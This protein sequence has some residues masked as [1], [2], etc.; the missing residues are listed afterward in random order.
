MAKF[1]DMAIPSHP[2]IVIS[3]PGRSS[4]KTTVTIGLA[5]ALTRKAYTVQPFKKGPDYIDPMWLTAASGR[6]CYNLDFYLMGE[7]N[8]IDSFQRRSEGADLS[9][10]EGNMGLYDGPDLMGS[11][12]TAHLAQI[13]ESPV[14]LVI[15]ARG[16]T[17]GVAALVLGYQ[18]FQPDLNISGVIL[19]QVRGKRHESKLI[20]ALNHYCDID[21][22]GA[23]PSDKDF[24][25]PERHLGLVPIGEN[26]EM[27][28]VI[29]R[30]E[31]VVRDH[32]DLDRFVE[33]ANVNSKQ[34]KPSA[35]D[36]SRTPFIISASSQPKDTIKIGI[37]KDQAFNFYYPDNL[38]ALTNA[39]AE[40]IPFNTLVDQ[41][42]PNVKGLYIG[43]GFPEVFMK[44]LEG[45][46]ALRKAIKKAIDNGMP[47]Y[48][49]CGGLM[50]LA[51]N[52]TW[53]NETRKMVGGIPCDIH[54]TNKPK[55]FGYTVLNPTVSKSWFPMDK[56]M[57]AHEFHYSEAVNMGDVDCI[58]SVKRGYGLD[59]RRDGILYKNVLASYVH[60]HSFSSPKWAESFVRFVQEIDYS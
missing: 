37:A 22:L 8:I 32:V 2:R 3:A 30:I 14:I 9:I 18:Q 58:Y 47:I 26:N 48:A 5:R 21:V 31:K 43:G 50:Y 56:E 28:G 59:G 12:S 41:E 60:L 23:I 55:G 11:G 38:E 52:I 17:R 34:V 45:N 13:L 24:E 36:S 20:S 46:I 57:K 16:M 42:L 27:D 7:N 39:G 6:V 33:K 44:E 35:E 25:I 40:L 4:G 19:N 1:K 54:Q 53:N 49:E 15:N 29:D 10:I 51:R